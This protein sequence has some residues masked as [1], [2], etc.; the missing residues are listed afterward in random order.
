MQSTIKYTPIENVRVNRNSLDSLTYSV[1]CDCKDGRYHVW[2][3][4]VSK[5]MKAGDNN[6]YKNPL[7]GQHFNTRQL[8][9]GLPKNA[10]MIEHM[11][12]IAETNHLFDEC[13][14]RLR[15]K[16]AVEDR[17]NHAAYLIELQKQAGPKLYVVLKDLLP[18]LEA[19]GMRTYE[20]RA[21]LREAEE[22]DAH[23]SQ[24]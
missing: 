17:E 10:A 5:K 22:G 18:K 6:L 13:D 12:V 11:L 4:A 21:A 15:E 8:R 23:G 16:Q 1:M 14:A 7:P 20:V 19:H 9:A 2:V 24:T 3:D